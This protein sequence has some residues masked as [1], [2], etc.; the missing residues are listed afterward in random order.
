VV[1]HRDLIA[2][3]HDLYEEIDMASATAVAAIAIVSCVLLAFAVLALLRARSRAA[4]A[5]AEAARMSSDKPAELREGEILLA[6]VVEH[7]P[8]HEVA[9]RVEIQQHGE[10]S[11]SSG[12]W[13]HR[14]TEIDRK[15]I[16]APFYLKL[17]DGT[18][19]RVE[20]PRDVEVADDLDGK[21]LISNTS[22]IRSAEL[23]PGESV[24][25]Q[26]WLERGDDAMIPEAG[27][28]DVTWGWVLRPARGRMLLSSHPLG[29]GLRS[30]ADFHRWYGRLALVLLAIFH[31]TLAGFYSR[32]SAKVV[33][34]TIVELKH[35]TST[36]S[37]GDTVNHYDIDVATPSGR[38][39]EF[40]LASS[41]FGRLQRGIKVPVRGGQLGAGPTLAYP[42]VA[43]AMFLV[44]SLLVTY[45]LR[46]R[47]SRPWYRRRVNDSGSGRLPG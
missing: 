1:A 10:E 3:A 34:G 25:A 35:S 45:R 16:V 18:R 46:R 40:S 33:E 11:E 9:V 41:D 7:A 36:D 38:R 2:M 27:Y 20:A 47:A 15:T 37:D 26:G 24:Y 8:G 14:W 29:A 17:A 30:R 23:I 31:V 22:R 12:S 43:I 5:A 4:L 39:H 44:M 21:V 13:S 32:A 6:G 42:H 19:V 28:R